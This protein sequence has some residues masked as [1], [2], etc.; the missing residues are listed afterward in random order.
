MRRPQRAFSP[1]LRELCLSHAISYACRWS[2][3]G[4]ETESYDAQ[5]VVKDSSELF[6][7]F[8]DLLVDDEFIDQLYQGEVHLL[9]SRVKHL[10]PN[11]FLML[12][13]SSAPAQ[14]TALVRFIGV[15]EPLHQVYDNKKDKTFGISPR[16]R[17]QTFGMDL[18]LDD[19]V[20]I[21]TLV[22]KAG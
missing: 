13:S 12:I 22:G 1:N 18:L 21:V 6:S 4:I 15:D 17:E 14:K 11:Q 2:S 3:L 10:F 16:N 9:K 7:G 8:K 5:S 20:P 19:D